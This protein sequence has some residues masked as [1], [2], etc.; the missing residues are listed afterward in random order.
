[1]ATWICKVCGYTHQGDE[2]PERCPQCGAAKSKF[3]REKLSSGCAFRMFFIIVMLTVIVF[4]LFAC[5]APLTVDNS[6]VKTVELDKY[7]G[8]WYELARFDH[9]FE[10]GMEHC[11][12][13][14]T[15]QK[16]G[17]IRVTNRGKKDGEWKTSV[18][19]GKV[20][21]EPGVLRVSFFGPFY[22]DYRIMMLAPDYSYALV[23]GGGDD[24]LW[25]LSRTPQLKQETLDQIVYEAHQRGY[26]T[27]NLIWVDQSASQ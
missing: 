2:A 1:M 25:I 13:T 8:D 19:K 27:S 7:A 5:S 4:S 14:Y 23:G 18:G 20:T 6:V 16:D 22:S 24:Y 15:L 9:R 17:T 21:G 11:R 10:R 26:K 3:Y 12:T